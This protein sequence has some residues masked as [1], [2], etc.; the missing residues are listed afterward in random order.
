[1]Q[2]TL[3]S[4]PAAQQNLRSCISRLSV[5][6]LVPPP[7][8]ARAILQRADEVHTALRMLADAQTSTLVI[9]GDPG[10][11]KSTLAAL[12]Y[13]QL[14]AVAT[15]GKSPWQYFAWLTLGP[16]AT[17]PDC[18]SALLA[19]ISALGLLPINRN[20]FY[21]LKPEQQIAVLYEALRRPQGGA[22]IVLDQ[23]EELLDSE[24]LEGLAGR[25]AIMQFLMM[26]QHDLG[27]SR[28]ILTSIRSPYQAQEGAR[29]RSYLVSRVSLPEGVALLQQR[30]ISGS[31]QELSLVWQRCAG[32]AYALVLFVALSSL[33][34]YSLSYLL[35]SPDCLPLWNGDVTLNI[36]HAISTFLNPIQRA[37]LR[38]LCLFSEPVP[39]DGIITA[40]TG[41][42]TTV[43]TLAFERE[44][45]TLARLSLVQLLP[46]E[47]TGSQPQYSLHALLRQYFLEHYIDGN[48]R[49][50][51]GKL[52][53]GVT[54]EP[55]AMNVSSE[56]REIAL[57]AG[58]M[59]VASYYTR[60]AQQ[61]C[62]PREAR[63]SM[64]DVEPMLAVIAHLCLGWHWQEACDMLFGEGLHESLL[65]W[66]A[67]NTLIRLY[68]DMAPPKGKVSRYDEGMI[69]SQLGMLYGRLADYAQSEACYARAFA[70]QRELH[71]IHGQKMALISQGEIF[72]SMGD[73]RRAKANYEQAQ[74]L[75][76]QQPDPE[77]ECTLLHSLGQLALAEKNYAVALMN[78]LQ[79]LQL[80]LQNEDKQSQGQILTS[81]GML[82]YEQKRLPEALALLIYAL[83]L[84]VAAR[85]ATLSSLASFLAS[86]E[87]NMGVEPFARLRQEA[88]KV[89]GKVLGDLGVG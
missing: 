40:T 82:L 17:L 19:S 30:G 10:A 14:Q 5:H 53:L 12:V 67:W 45:Q 72:S 34:G 57:A 18:L 27:A 35:N 8:D 79:A 48:D 32:H 20:E 11:G 75:N 66:G 13:R 63:A 78:Y 39:L 58:H 7:I 87:Q 88:M 37:I 15:T 44:L 74:Q 68:S 54:N 73:L 46:Q 42:G 85:D 4:Q 23:F 70:I 2:Q 24:K 65:R 49:H 76:Q 84:R 28:V 51:S 16:N 50:P 64:Q 52:A 6:A 56:A 41:D 60:V 31:P 89:Q 33:S 43:D 25:G 3:H 9:A 69:F 29:T 77:V 59:R 80:A 47:Y 36:I 55:N 21:L 83:Q 26:L 81:M 62:P 61:T 22:L 38:A 86:L 1:M 71:D